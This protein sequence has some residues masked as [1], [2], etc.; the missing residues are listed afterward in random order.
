MWKKYFK[1]ARPNEDGVYSPL[2]S[3]GGRSTGEN[4]V[5]INNYPN[6]L[7]ESYLG[8]PNRIE[9]YENWNQMDSDS[10]IN[11][12]LDIL[13][14]FSTQ[15]NEQ[16][17][18][19]FKVDFKDTP[20]ET[21]TK[22]IKKQLQSWYY[23]NEFNKRMFRL[24]R[25]V[26]KYGDQVFIRDPETFKLFYVEM[27]NVIKVIVN[28]SKGK[29]PEQYIIR[30]INPNFENLTVTQVSAN[31]LYNVIPSGAGTNASSATY[32]TPNSPYSSSSRFVHGK[33]ENCVDAEHI[34]HFS[35]T[36]G[37]DPNWPFG[38]SIL[39]LVYK[40]YK[41]KELL[42]DSIIIYRVQRAPERR[43]FKID[44]GDM[45]Q[46]L[47][48]AFIEK[49]KNEIHQRRIPGRSGD[50][51]SNFMDSTYSGMGPN[52]DF[53]FPTTS[54]IKLDEKIKLLDGRSVSLQEIINEFNNFIL[55]HI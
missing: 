19:C 33:N 54:C 53:F 37:L 55:A 15:N 5:G 46:H 36:E 31:N 30:N 2:S 41:Q 14:E 20:T 12:A 52:M 40:V 42:E 38:N 49:V 8:C 25:N 51:N 47:A 24:F 13:A 10:E 27:D 9:R 50:G 7:R 26:L 43:V 48:M 44:V 28:E 17:N 23:L 18:M 39:E 1:K 45:P 34:V 29:K 35:L 6:L 4:S 22:I 3:R 11:S 16:D 32:N 21:E